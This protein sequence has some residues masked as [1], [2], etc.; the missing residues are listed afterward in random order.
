MDIQF[1]ETF[2]E[3]AKTLNFREASENIGVVQSTVSNRIQALEDFYK[4]PL[5]NR[6]NKKVRLS[7]TGKR[8][9][10]YAERIVKLQYEAVRATRKTEEVLE[11]LSIGIDSSLY[12]GELIQA[13][14]SFTAE[15]PEIVLS[16]DVAHSKDIHRSVI[17][18]VYDMGFVYSKSNNPD[19]VF[20]PY[21][22][23]KFIFAGLSPEEPAGE[24]YVTKQALLDLE[25]VYSDYGRKF[26]TWCEQFIP[27]DYTYSV[28]LAKGINP[29]HYICGSKKFG[30]MLES[31]LI[32]SGLSDKL[33][34]I[35][36]KG[37][38]FPYLQSYLLYA[39]TDQPRSEIMKFIGVLSRQD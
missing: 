25:L 30:F 13:I 34:N 36:V 28:Y 4:R 5:F 7:S 15:H 18:G 6:T 11:T 37:L 9:L 1:Y 23:D 24:P 22:R 35:R 31:E 26:K 21:K 14:Q 10:P 38:D 27:E 17:D 29:A 39:K 2:I 3:V 19:V 12:T 20:T 16:I 33:Q 32:S 8:L